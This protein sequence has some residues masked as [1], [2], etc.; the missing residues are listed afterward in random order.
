MIHFQASL[1]PFQIS[2]AAKPPAP[3]L[4]EIGFTG[5]DRYNTL[6]PGEY[7]P[8][9]SGSLAL[10]TYDR[11]RTHH[12]VQAVEM[13]CSLPIIG[14]E[15]TVNPGGDG[16]ADREAAELIQTNLANMSVPWPELI[17]QMLSSLMY[18]FAAHEKIFEEA[19][20]Y[21]R[22]RK[23]ADRPQTTVSEFMY[24]DQGGLAGLKQSGYAPDGTYRSDVP[25]PIDRLLITTY[26][27][28]GGNAAGRP[29]SRAMYAPWWCQTN[30]LRL[31][32][33][34]LEKTLVGTHMA[35]YPSGAS[36][37]D[38]DAFLRTLENI[39]IHERAA[40]IYPD[41]WKPGILEGSRSPLD[42]LPMVRYF[43][44]CIAIAALTQLLNLGMTDTGSFSLSQV[45]L[46][47]YIMALQALADLIADNFNRYAIPQLCGYNFPGLAVFPTLEHTPISQIVSLE[48][49]AELLSKLVS[50]RLLT[51]ERSTEEYIRSLI[52]LPDLPEDLPDTGRAAAPGNSPDDDAA[53]D[54]AGAADPDATDDGDSSTGRRSRAASACPLCL[55]S[56]D[57]QVAAAGALFASTTDTWQTTATALVEAIFGRLADAARAALTKSGSSDPLD[58][59]SRVQAALSSFR[60]PEAARYRQA[61]LAYMTALV[62]GA[63][64]AA[65]QATGTTPRP[66]P[67]AL[68]Q[69]IRAE[70][71]QLSAHYL[72]TITWAFT[73]QLLEGI[74]RN[75]GVDQILSDALVSATEAS[76]A[77]LASDT[78][79]VL[80]ALAEL[81]I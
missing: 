42:A 76:N 8:K 51:P 2:L 64:E 35:A 61:L 5:I 53:D 67:R 56:T 31:V 59:A 33:I 9:L 78:R 12:Q 14:A 40:F 72:E 22:W 37:D 32:M 34:G 10:E 65:A 49:A 58:R 3:P 6:T 45:H 52:G 23:L 71:E 80:S 20:G 79:Y 1:R 39:R 7:N 74:T 81:S 30:L 21:V 28:E 27:R 16:A 63:R 29:L 25:I 60:L 19:N 54:D 17:Q 48:A 66:L 68:Q 57:D 26:R 4:G 62:D 36:Q 46:R 15:W 75:V 77:Q 38:R 50:S 13:S 24:D 70:A 43:N 44:D 73:Q 41:T 18:G 69:F 47:I 11:M 55:S